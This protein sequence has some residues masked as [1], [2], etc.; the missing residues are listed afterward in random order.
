ME[1]KG[2]EQRTGISPTRRHASLGEGDKKES[3][4]GAQLAIAARLDRV[5]SWTV[6][7]IDRRRH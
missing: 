1:P 7:D 3:K 4:E 5:G 6:K 2:A